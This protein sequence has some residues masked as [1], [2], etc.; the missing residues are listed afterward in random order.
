MKRLL[1]L[2]V[3]LGGIGLLVSRLRRRPEPAAPYVE[4]DPRALELRRRLDASRR[5][6]T[7]PAEEEAD[8]APVDDADD[9]ADLVEARRRVHERGRAAA[10]EMRR[11]AADQAGSHGNAP[12]G[13]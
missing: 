7:S 6:P 4:S 10:A 3:A 9:T 1:A 11:A 8:A 2:L 13:S 5:E 12:D